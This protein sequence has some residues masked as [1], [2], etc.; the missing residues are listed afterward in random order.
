MS[1]DDLPAGADTVMTKGLARLFKAAGCYPQSC[2]ACKKEIQ[3]G[4]VFKLVPHR[5]LLSSLLEDEMCCAKCGAEE[6]KKRDE[7]LLRS[8]RP[9]MHLDEKR[10]W[11]YS[12]PSKEQTK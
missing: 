3:T 11:G 12:R 10:T 4:D 7:N 6:L 9:A 8:A 1:L 5:K 2:H